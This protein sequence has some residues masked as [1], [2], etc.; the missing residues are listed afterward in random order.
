[1]SKKRI[2]VPQPD[3]QEK[4]YMRQAGNLL[5]SGQAGLQEGAYTQNMMAPYLYDLAGMQATYE[6]RTPQ[7]A[8]AQAR[9]DQLTSELTQAQSLKKMGKGQ[10]QAALSKLA[11]SGEFSDATN[12]KGKLK[13]RK[14]TK[15]LQ[16]QLGAQSRE[17]GDLA[18]APL[19]I[20]GLKE[21]PT[22]TAQRAREQALLKQ[23]QDMLQGSLSMNN[24]DVLNADPALKR[25]LLEEQ[26]KMQQSQVGQFGSLADANGGT[27]GAVQNAAMAQRRAEAISNSRRENIGLYQGLQTQQAGQNQQLGAARQ[28]MASVPSQLQ[29]QSALN[30]GNLAQGYGSLLQVKAGQRDA[31]FKANSFNQTQPTLFESAMKGVGSLLTPMKSDSGS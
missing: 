22:Q 9:H 6:D 31:Q 19:R 21:N 2:S 16:A 13:G 17:M 10:R 27:I 15:Y 14:L 18:N 3:S 20:T 26:A 25:Q 28:G 30:F 4:A 24:E 1:M 29:Q 7:M 11:A 8:A 12:K 5:Q 23:E